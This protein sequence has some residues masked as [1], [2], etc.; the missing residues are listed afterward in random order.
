MGSKRQSHRFHDLKKGDYVDLNPSQR[1]PGWKCGEIRRLDQKSGQVQVVYESMDKNYLYWA[2]LDNEQEIAE[3]TSKS[4]TVHQT[5]MD[6]DEQM[7][8]FARIRAKRFPRYPSEK[9]TNTYGIGDWLEVQDTQ[10][11]QW[12]TATVIDKENNWIVVHF[13][14]WPSKY[15]QKIHTEKHALRLR[16][17]GSGLQETQEEK[18]IK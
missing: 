5:Q 4:G 14:G 17:L 16:E 18:D 12:V 10:T 8:A 13:D 3:F 11:L 6:A 1:H 2:H 15:D 9:V 7:E